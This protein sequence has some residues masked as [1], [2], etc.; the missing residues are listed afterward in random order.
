MTPSGTISHVAPQEPPA[1]VFKRIVV[2]ISGEMLGGRDAG[3]GLKTFQR[4]AEEIEQVRALGVEVGV[5]VGGGN[6]FRGIDS[7]RK[8]VDRVVADQVGMIG[9]MVNALLLQN[10][11]EQRH[12]PTRVMTAIDM[13]DVAEPYIRRRAITHLES[14][15]VVIFA[16]GTGNPFFTTDTA[17]AL[18]ASEVGADVLL[19]GTK[20]DGVY[21]SD[22]VKD[23][24][25]RFYP[26]VTFSEVLAKNLRVMDATAISLCRDN[27]LTIIVF[28]LHQPG[29]LKRIVLGEHIGTFVTDDETDENRKR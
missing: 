24:K 5:V 8:N 15:R 21:S 10:M 13:Q 4:V 9:T 2:K 19:K 3:G 28:N 29:N 7:A 6:I 18:R 12:I 25:A 23:A 20:V 27:H 22:P 11:L 16:C 17:A 26:R 14:K 1:P